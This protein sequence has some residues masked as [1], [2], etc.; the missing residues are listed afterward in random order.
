MLQSKRK[1]KYVKDIVP[2]A[3]SSASTTFEPTTMKGLNIGDEIILKMT[4]EGAIRG[5]VTEKETTMFGS[6]EKRGNTYVQAYEETMIKA[7]SM[8]PD[9][10]LGRDYQ[11][12][13]RV[14]LRDEMP[15]LQPLRQ[16]QS[17]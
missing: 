6:Q 8:R 1:V 13:E 2:S 14:I 3:S 9:G 5:K 10:M 15:L 4:T 12:I 11:A 7:R 17:K 16:K